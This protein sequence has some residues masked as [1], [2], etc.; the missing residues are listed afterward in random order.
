MNHELPHY[1]VCEACGQA[2]HHDPKDIPAD[3]YR[4]AHLCPECNSGPY[5]FARDGSEAAKLML[6]VLVSGPML[7]DSHVHAHG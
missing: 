6:S 4:K 2:W 5:R 3:G 7:E 1:H